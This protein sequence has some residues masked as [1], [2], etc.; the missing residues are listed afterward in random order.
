MNERM[1]ARVLVP[2]LALV[3]AS[4][5]AC[6][7]GAPWRRPRQRPSPTA[8]RRRHAAPPSA[9]PSPSAPPASPDPLAEGDYVSPPLTAEM[10]V[11][12]IEAHGLDPADARVAPSLERVSR[13][14]RSSRC[15][16]GWPADA[17]PE[18]GRRHADG[19][20]EGCVRVHRRPH[21]RRRRRLPDRVRVSL[22]RGQA[23]RERPQGM[24]P[25]PMDLI[26][27][28]AIYESAPL[29]ACDEHQMAASRSRAGTGRHAGRGS[30]RAPSSHAV[31]G[32]DGHVRAGVGRCRRRPPRRPVQAPSSR[33][34]RRR[35]DPPPSS[36]PP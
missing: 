36:R 33:P 27:Q 7:S 5:T 3:A 31:A 8:A 1:L 15:A 35:P 16:R 2:I 25:D 24:H 14:T 28:V 4:V 22:G 9:A 20:M 29:R 23:P 13:R 6:S 21:V 17:A 32:I 30:V 11:A 19:R 34:M 26:A 12:A 18:S 10:M